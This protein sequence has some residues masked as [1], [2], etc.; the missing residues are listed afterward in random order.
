MKRK[1]SFWLQNYNFIFY[2]QQMKRKNILF[3]SFY[4]MITLLLGCNLNFSNKIKMP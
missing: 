3:K 4:D 1:I 2:Y